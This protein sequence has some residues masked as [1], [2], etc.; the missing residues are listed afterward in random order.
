MLTPEKVEVSGMKRMS[1]NGNKKAKDYYQE[2]DIRA[3]IEMI[4]D[5]IDDG[6]SFFVD[7]RKNENHELFQAFVEYCL[8]H[9]ISSMDWRTKCYN[10]TVSK[11]FTVADEAM[12]ILLL[13]NNA[14]DLRLIKDKRR[15]LPRKQQNSKF[16]KIDKE[17]DSGES[18][19]GWHKKGIKRYNELFKIIK[20]SRKLRSSME[21]ENK[22]LTK[23]A[24]IKGKVYR[25]DEE[26]QEDYNND[27][28]D[29]D[30]FAMDEF[31]IEEMETSLDDLNGIRS[32]AV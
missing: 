19:Q 29:D 15:K 30:V 14:K 20:E 18:F 32:Q 13:E 9:S 2:T 17:G 22:L 12:A 16:T 11:M 24:T 8:I 23:F 3:Q 10:T 25:E 21:L 26:E 4:C 6:T 1:N 28:D 31:E 27:E 5:K 7:M